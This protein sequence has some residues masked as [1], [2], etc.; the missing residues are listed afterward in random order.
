MYE[1][2]KRCK[3]I[4]IEWINIEWI[5]IR[6]DIQEN[7]ITTRTTSVGCIFF[8]IRSIYPVNVT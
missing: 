5:N 6:D 4:N 7:D 8:S 1:Q 2:K 3:A